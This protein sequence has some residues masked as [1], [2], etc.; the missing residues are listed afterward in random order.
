VT[1]QDLSGLQ[2]AGENLRFDFPAG[3]ELAPGKFLVVAQN[4]AAFAAAYGSTIPVLG[5]WSGQLNRFGTQLGIFDAANHTLASV[6]FR[7]SLPWPTNADAGAALQLVDARRDGSRVGN[8]STSAGTQWQHVVQSGTAS[9]STLYLYLETVGDVYVD[10]VKLVAGNDA[11]VGE[12]LLAN[13]DF[14]SDFPGPFAIG[15]DGNMAQSARSTTV[16]RGGNAS[17]HLVA[18]AGGTTRASS[19]YQDLATPLTANAPYT[20]SYW[21]LPKTAG[22]TL[23]L[24][25]SGSGIKSTVNVATG[26]TSAPG[27]TP[28]TTN[29]RCRRAAGVPAAVDQRGPAEQHDRPAGQQEPARAVARTGEPRQPARRPRRLDARQQLHEPRPVDLP[30]PAR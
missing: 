3:T 14:E 23:T 15:T 18:T 27:F 9:S 21:Y 26:A 17:L 25:L 7:A 24:R 11:D 5:Q 8:W 1:T 13:G 30:A 19:V 28:G 4:T 2:L 10:D 22:G 20:L 6:D 16:R 29:Q 12:N